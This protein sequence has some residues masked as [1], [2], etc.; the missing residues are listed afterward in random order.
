MTN[1]PLETTGLMRILVG[2]DDPLVAQVI[3]I[4]ARKAGIIVDHVANGLDAADR[5][6]ASPPDHFDA[7]LLDMRMPI[8]DGR[9][10]AR[11]IRDLPYARGTIPIYA[12][13]SSETEL[14]RHP[15]ATWL[16]D[17]HLTKPLKQSDLLTLLRDH[18]RR[19]SG[20]Q[21]KPA[22][23]RHRDAIVERIEH[24]MR[25]IDDALGQADRQKAGDAAKRMRLGLLGL[26]PEDLIRALHLF[27]LSQAHGRGEREPLEDLRQC[28]VTARTLL[29]AA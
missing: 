9:E 17:G 15:W 14:L 24:G 10:A 13:S 11:R 21:A 2:E 1:N 7:V 28:F 4:S 18:D 25:E 23:R 27:E 3:E 26:V 20:R 12:M 6:A 22:D 29:I 19:T 16:F 5:V 8:L